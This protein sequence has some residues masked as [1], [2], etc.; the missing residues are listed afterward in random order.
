MRSSW[1]H[2]WA[3]LF[4]RRV[5]VAFQTQKKDCFKERYYLS[6]LWC[7]KTVHTSCLSNVVVHTNFFCISF[8]QRFPLWW[9]I[10][11][12]KVWITSFSSILFIEKFTCLTVTL[13]LFLKTHAI[14]G[15]GSWNSLL[16]EYFKYN[17][18]KVN[19]VLE[20][21]SRK[22]WTALAGIFSHEQ[23]NA[24]NAS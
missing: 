4:G 13:T 24:R 23:N 9:R 18:F 11:Y 15:P 20:K 21:T 2:H 10:K 3:F 19:S 8:L 1:V 16:M 17:P 14:Q 6:S 5:V 7:F 12:P 22:T